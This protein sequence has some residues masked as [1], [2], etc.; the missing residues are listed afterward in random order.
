M[1]IRKFRAEGFRNIERCEID[2]SA[3]TNLIVGNNA[4][5]KTNVIEGIYLFSRGRS[6]RTSDDRDMIKFGH[7]GFRVS[8]EYETEGGVS[9]LEYALFGRTRR[10]MKNG[11]KLSGASEMLGNFRSVLFYPDD[12]RLVKGN[13]EERRSFLNVA[14]SQT[15]PLYI[16]DYSRFKTALENRNALLKNASKGVYFD[17]GELLAWG[18]VMAEYSAGIY[19]ERK[20]YVEELSRYSKEHLFEL[21]HGAEELSLV[22][23]SDIETDALSKEE[24]VLEYKEVYRRNL[25][26]EK[27]AGTSLYG[28]QRD[29]IVINLSGHDARSFASQGQQRSIVLSMKLGEG[30]IIHSRF[31]EYPVYLFDDVLSEL[32]D[33]RR[34]YLAGKTDSL[35]TVITSCEGGERY[36]KNI[37]VIIAEG[38]TYVPS[39][40]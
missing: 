38:G 18:D 2:F 21:S 17:E 4:E 29:D 32:D 33:E 6:F 27:C 23:K 9:T 12:L 3:G 31:G 13:P 7:D 10:R 5:G 24:A 11:Y 40:R 8:I 30:D 36:L 1:R 34:T 25:D 22:Y 26:R 16:S 37:N 20:K 14:L 35:Q 15:A 39:H 28:P 19:I